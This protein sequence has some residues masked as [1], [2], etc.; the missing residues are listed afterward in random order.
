MT[1]LNPSN[2]PDIALETTIADLQM[3]VANLKQQIANL[4]N[5]KVLIG[6]EKVYVK[7]M[8]TYK[9]FGLT[10]T[11]IKYVWAHVIPVYF[12]PKNPH[13]N[14]RIRQYKH[15]VFELPG[16]SEKK[17]SYQVEFHPSNPTELAKLP[18]K[19][20]T[21]DNIE[22]LKTGPHD[23]AYF[24]S[25]ENLVIGNLADCVEPDLSSYPFVMFPNLSNVT[26]R[27]YTHRD[28]GYPGFLKALAY[29][30]SLKNIQVT[31]STQSDNWNP[32]R[33]IYN[34]SMSMEI[35]GLYKEGG[36]NFQVLPCPKYDYSSTEFYTES[37]E[38]VFD[39]PYEEFY[40]FYNK[41]YTNSNC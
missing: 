26:V 18:V 1:S 10:N 33:S 5:P 30:P 28:I 36:I 27:N 25:V 2:T 16:N 31:L 14:L 35:E 3:E 11:D 37:Q 39:F 12:D 40:A 29:I 38:K 32:T 23:Y 13:V 6:H 22:Q 9:Y 34:H 7:T 19:S 24:P 20:L 15:G 21:I 17:F 8:H 41:H 4:S